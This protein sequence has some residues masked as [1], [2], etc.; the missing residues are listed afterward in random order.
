[1]CLFCTLFGTVHLCIHFVK[2]KWKPKRVARVN[3]SV[4]RLLRLAPSWHISSMDEWMAIK[5]GAAIVGVQRMIHNEFGDG[6][7]Y[8]RCLQPFSFKLSFPAI[9]WERYYF[10]RLLVLGHPLLCGLAS[11]FH[12]VVKGIEHCL[13]QWSNTAQSTEQGGL[14]QRL[15]LVWRWGLWLVSTHNAKLSL[16]RPGI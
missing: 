7:I 10:W 5:F 1:M 4:G 15:A 13:V 6:K 14:S 9:H 16:I 3:Q 8:N 11:I 2:T 12:C